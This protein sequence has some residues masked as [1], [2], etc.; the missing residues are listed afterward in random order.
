MDLIK[1]K[2]Y[3]IDQIHSSKANQMTSLYH[4]SGVGFK[5]AI[6]NLGIFRNEDKK[7]VGVLQWGCSFQENI[8]LDRYVKEPI[9][10]EEYLELNRFSMAD[11][12]GKNSESQAISLGIK[13]IKQNMPN[14]RLLVS[15]AGRKEGNYGYIYQ[16]TN[17]EYLGYFISNGFWYVNGEERHLITLWSRYKRYGDQNLP[18][19]EALCK[20]YED[21][22]STKTKQFIYIQRLDKSLTVASPILPYPKPSNE[23][24]I[25]VEE[26]IY[27]QNDEVFNNHLNKEKK[28]VEYYHTKETQLFSN[29]T[30]IRRGEKEPQRPKPVAVY[31]A[32]GNLENIFENVKVINIAGYLESGIRESI[33]NKKCYKNKYFRF[34]EGEEPDENIEVPYICIIDE[35]PF[36]SYAEAGRYLGVSRQAIHSAW[37][38]KAK[39]A[40]GKPVIWIESDLY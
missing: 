7:M 14:I 2:K 12:E 3:F 9:K 35:I 30:L 18:F 20:L 16:A 25:K 15:Y 40:G 8:R 6:L 11:S 38:R 4:Y 36:N 29:A 34:Y 21:V 23:F 26:Y 37:K 33:S 31:D 24:P 17:W 5:K 27:K 1:N 22:R 28:I 32:G 19:T 39:T 10:K 13:W